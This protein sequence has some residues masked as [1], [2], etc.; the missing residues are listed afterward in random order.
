M[1]EYPQFTGP[2]HRP[3]LDPLYVML[4]N[5]DINIDFSALSGAKSISMTQEDLILN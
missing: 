5:C 3:P 1:M 2:L 4:L